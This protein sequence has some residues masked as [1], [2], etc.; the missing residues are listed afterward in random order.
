MN[1]TRQKDRYQG[2]QSPSGYYKD[3]RPIDPWLLQT[4]WDGWASERPELLVRLRPR[5]GRA[6]CATG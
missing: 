1:T 6:A 4:V 2:G 3:I 5:G